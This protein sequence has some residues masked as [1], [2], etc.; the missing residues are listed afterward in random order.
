MMNEITRELALIKN[1][2]EIT[3][4]QVQIWTKRIE[5]EQSKP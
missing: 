3:S 2:N 5:A 4:E 1:T